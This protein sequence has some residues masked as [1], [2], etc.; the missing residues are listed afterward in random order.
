M[1][2]LDCAVGRV[3]RYTRGHI[4]SL[5][6]TD[7]M[8]CMICETMGPTVVTSQDGC[9]NSNNIFKMNGNWEPNT[10]SF[11]SPSLFLTLC[12]HLLEE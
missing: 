11:L 9:G 12:V 4:L 8:D 3:P 2:A 10:Y 6:N 1:C 5:E 7:C